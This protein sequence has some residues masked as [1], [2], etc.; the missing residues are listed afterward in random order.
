ML[1]FF[2][3]FNLDYFFKVPAESKVVYFWLGLYLLVLVVDLVLYFIYR[4]KSRA[5]KPYRSFANKMIWTEV[6][7]SVLGLFFVFARYENLRTFSWRFW[8]Y[9]TALALIAVDVWLHLERR[10]LKRDLVHYKSEIRKQKWLKKKR[11]KR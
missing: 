8:Q 4:K 11:R 2:S 3:R 9:L 5:E 10:K 7:I 6:P 1:D